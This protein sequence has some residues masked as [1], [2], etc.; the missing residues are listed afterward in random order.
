MESA[1][2]FET[3][4]IWTRSHTFLA[5]SCWSRQDFIKPGWLPRLSDGKASA[6]KDDIRLVTIDQPLASSCRRARRGQAVKASRCN[7]HCETGRSHDVA[8]ELLSA[9]VVHRAA[10]THRRLSTFTC[11]EAGLPMFVRALSHTHCYLAFRHSLM[12][13]TQGLTCGRSAVIGTFPKTVRTSASKLQKSASHLVGSNAM[14]SA[15]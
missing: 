2:P 3:K 14:V 11:V 9:L 15:P 13:R 7:S 8:N 6:M 5:I 1:P 4:I 10:R 12:L